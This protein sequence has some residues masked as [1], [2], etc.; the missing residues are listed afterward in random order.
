MIPKIIHQIWI[1][2]YEPPVAAMTTWRSMNPTFQYEFWDDARC[3]SF[4]FKN[5]AK[6][7]EQ[8]ELAGKA[9]LMRYEILERHGGVYIDA[10]SECI[11]PLPDEM[12]DHDSFACWENEM[13]RRGLISNG[14]LGATQGNKL[15]RSLIDAASTRDMSIGRA[16]LTVG[17]MFLTQMVALMNYED[18]H[19]YPS[20][21]FIPR[22]YSGAEYHGVGPIY[23]KQG[24]GSTLGSYKIR[25]HKFENEA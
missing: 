10:D 4:G 25:A 21:Y 6:I 5:S 24:W 1:G 9:D 15:M 22:H 7:A 18:L 14:Y 12:L 3:A 8:P 16:W 13:I 2:P 23:A 20:Y 11:M 19:V 17:P